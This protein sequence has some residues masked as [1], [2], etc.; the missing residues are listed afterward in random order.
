MAASKPRTHH[1]YWLISVPGGAQGFDALSRKITARGASN[2]A[3]IFRFEIPREL[4]VGTLDELMSLSDDI[5]KMELT[6]AAT[7]RKIGAAFLSILREDNPSACAESALLVGGRSLCFYTENFE[8]NSSKYLPSNTCREIATSICQ[9]IEQVEEGFRE[10]MI[11]FSEANS[12][13]STAERSQK[14]TLVMRDLSDIV[15]E[16]D[17]PALSSALFQ[18]V[19]AVVPSFATKEWENHY[20]GGFGCQLVYNPD[21]Q[22]TPYTVKPTLKKP[23]QQVGKPTVSHVEDSAQ[24]AAF[25]ASLTGSRGFLLNAVVPDS[26]RL[27]FQDAE[28]ALYTVTLFRCC[29]KDFANRAREARYTIREFVP[30]AQGARAGTALVETLKT[31]REERK[32]DL[33]VFCKNWFKESFQAW[34][35]LK[36]LR[37]FVQSILRYGVP[38]EFQA[39]LISPHASG[40][41]PK[42]RQALQEQFGNL[43]VT[44]EDPSSNTPALAMFGGKVYPY[45]YA[46][47]DLA[48]Y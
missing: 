37:T 45:V 34:I 8:W 36:A 18:T 2:L 27:I 46:D 25:N 14:S 48:M 17:L 1:L 32:Q 40:D 16:S 44:D 7:T 5:E 35:H 26:S 24:E 30:P 28:F 6:C 38:P 33:I 9:E 21:N 13:M 3:E 12:K 4:R 19:L 22:E 11:A 10:R 15:K 31:E 20:A 43:A 29:V 47:L 41:N 39:I 23:A 42:L